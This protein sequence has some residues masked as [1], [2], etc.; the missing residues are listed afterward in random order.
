MLTRI[1]ISLLSQLDAQ[2][3]LPISPSR[4]GKKRVGFKVFFF[5]F[6]I[7]K[8]FELHMVPDQPWMNFNQI[9]SERVS[10]SPRGHSLTLRHS[11]SA[12]PSHPGK[13]GFSLKFGGPHQINS[14]D[15]EVLQISN[16][17]DFV[18]RTR[19]LMLKAPV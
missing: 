12:S 4:P 7:T 2:R 16:L 9:S 1:S 10:V 8:V 13:S 11:I 17:I 3:Q 15:N 6:C 5:V 14:T 18:R 19:S